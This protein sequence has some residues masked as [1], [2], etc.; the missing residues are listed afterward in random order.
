MKMGCMNMARSLSE[1]P[2]DEPNEDREKYLRS[3]K[4]R[5]LV[6][7]TP[8]SGVGGEF[9]LPIPF[10]SKKKAFDYAR[11]CRVKEGQKTRIVW[12]H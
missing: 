5:W 2:D 11:E 4:N 3:L 7:I 12:Q 9:P 8:A 6:Y 10:R 1:L